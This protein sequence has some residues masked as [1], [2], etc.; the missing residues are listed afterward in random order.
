MRSTW[1]LPR[2]D[3]LRPVQGIEATFK[4]EDQAE[5]GEIIGPLIVWDHEKDDLVQE[6][7]WMPL[8]EA[9]K[10]AEKNGWRLTEDT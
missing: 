8:S 5:N 9:R 6:F 4:G 7:D 1:S 10:L 2:D 3:S